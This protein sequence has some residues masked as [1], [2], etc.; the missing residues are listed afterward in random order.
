[1]P[2]TALSPISSSNSCV[3]VGW[4]LWK[5]NNANRKILS[6]CPLLKIKG[7]QPTPPQSLSIYRDYETTLCSPCGVWFQISAPV[8]TMQTGELVGTTRPDPGRGQVQKRPWTWYLAI[9]LLK[10]RK[11]KAFMLFYIYVVLSIGPGVRWSP[12]RRSPCL[13]FGR[14]SQD[15]GDARSIITRPGSEQPSGIFLSCRHRHQPQGKAL[16]SAA[17][18][19]ATLP[20][21]L[22]SRR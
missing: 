3:V 9:M 17:A 1:M 21:S 18:Q 10:R 20:G 15:Q 4:H 2:L 22:Y 7:N 12:R 14:L 13:P 5:A 16:R 6:C 8:G 11:Q 19:P